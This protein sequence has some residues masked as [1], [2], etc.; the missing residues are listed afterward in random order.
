MA[1]PVIGLMSPG[2]MGHRVGGEIRKQGFRVVTSTTGRSALTQTRAERAGLDDV[3]SLAKIV[4]ASDVILSIMPPESAEEFAKQ[5]A[6]EVKKQGKSPIFVDCN[7]ISPVTM[8]R[9]DAIIR[10]AGAKC[11][12]AGIVGSPP[13]SGRIAPKI[14]VSG[15]HADALKFFTCDTMTMMDMGP[16]IGRASALKMCYAGLTKGTNALRTAVLL[17]GEMLGVGPELKRALADSQKQQWEQIN[18]AVPFLACDAGRWSGEMEQ[19]AET[20]ASAG[21]TDKIHKGAAEL[22]RFLDSTPLGAETRESADRSR[23]LD[24]TLAIYG[25]TIR[26]KKAAE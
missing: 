23:T 20:F 19:I 21:V 12:D 18:A 11:M 2:D 6:A 4:E 1:N 16:E 8:K 10:G 14:Y 25:D 26:G 13:G 9:I 24:Q 5:V 22:F 17:S 15:P 7:A 3:G